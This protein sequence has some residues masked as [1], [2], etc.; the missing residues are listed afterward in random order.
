MTSVQEHYTRH[1]GPVYAW[2]VGGVE[3]A[4]ETGSSELDSSGIVPSS[5]G[6]AVDLGAGFGMHA[7]PLACRGFNVL[8]MDTCIELLDEL[9]HQRASLPITT[10]RADL[11]LFQKYLTGRPNVVLCMGDTITH[12][13]DADTVT[14]LISMVSAELSVGGRFV[15]TFR[16]YTKPL[17]DVHRFINV[18]SDVRR[19]LTCFL[20]Y[21]DTHVTV[22]DILLERDGACWRQEVSAYEK[23][24]L[25]P[26][27][28]V[29]ILREN[30][31]EVFQSPGAAGMIRILAL[32]L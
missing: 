26:Q 8:A 1:L 12:L 14:R 19:I 20:E 27:W 5:G 22:H 29:S 17:S 24:R 32:R 28:L 2:M 4:I 21:G 13:A 30:A 23:L 11:L 7:V 10:V 25:S 3:S 16:D 18:R 31:F 15:L 9:N 6:L